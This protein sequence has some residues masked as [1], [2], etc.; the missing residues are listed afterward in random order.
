LKAAFKLNPFQLVLLVAITFSLLALTFLSSEISRGASRD[1]KLFTSAELSSTSLIVV[2][3]ESLA[4]TTKFSQWLGGDIERRDVQIARALLA[5][6]LGVVVS[7]NLSIGT[8]MSQRYFENLSNSDAILNDAQPGYL[9]R[10]EANKIKSRSIEF[11]DAMLLETRSLV[12][13]YQRALDQ[14]LEKSAL[15]RHDRAEKALLLLYTFLLVSLIFFSSIVYSLRKQ[16]RRNYHANLEQLR[17]INEA[18]VQLSETR[19]VVNQLELLDER[20]DIFI[21]TVNHELRTPLTSIVGYI[22]ILREK[23]EENGD[24][25]LKKIIEILERN[26]NNLLN[27]VQDILSL[28]NLESGSTGLLKSEVDL[29]EIAND[30]ILLLAPLAGSSHVS[31]DLKVEEGLPTQILANR[32][33]FLEVIT[34]LLGNAIKF[35]KREGNVRVNI[36][37]AATRDSVKMLKISV[38]DDGIGIPEDE[39]EEIFSS[40][41]RAS[42][43]RNSHITGTGLGLAITSRIIEE[44]HGN[45]TVE[46]VLGK[47]TTFV[48]EVPVFVLEIDEFIDSRKEDVLL[49]AIVALETCTI[50]ELRDT[51][52]EMLGVLGFYDLE[53]SG[54]EISKFATWFKANEGA[55]ES[56]IISRKLDVVERLRGNL[57]ELKSMKEM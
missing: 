4:Y 1:V 30:A 29:K 46:S 48:V 36:E 14:V 20:K 23:C 51:T 53:G 9:S 55:Q 50:S 37:K 39:L 26:S 21:S 15:D 34:N 28:T 57:A 12:A 43:A 45:I 47:G 52:H 11:I 25:D 35:S 6:R 3:R 7:S 31:V 24:E 19:M 8:Q 54:G 32:N 49:K 56:E 17:L 10:Q 13:A 40:F 2:Q 38:S 5:Q 42:N 41:F 27:L 18:V 22:D 16:Y 33:Q 44:H